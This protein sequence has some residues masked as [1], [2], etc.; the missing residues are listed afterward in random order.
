MMI[1]FPHYYYDSRY[2]SMSLYFGGFA[3]FIATIL[4][5]ADPIYAPLALTLAIPLP[6]ACV[7]L[8]LNLAMPD[9]DDVV[10]AR[11]WSA[12]GQVSALLMLPTAVLAVLS[13]VTAR[14]IG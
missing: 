5:I 2:A 12:M 8:L 9:Q 11:I 14:F 6:V 1:N 10:I 4:Q 3:F 7:A 13:D